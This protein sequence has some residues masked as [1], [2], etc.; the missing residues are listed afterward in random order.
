M[1]LLN[2]IQYNTTLSIHSQYCYESYWLLSLLLISWCCYVS[3]WVSFASFLLGAYSYSPNW[4]L[5]W[6]VEPP[7]ISVL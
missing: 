5:S 6:V 7:V 4:H 2:L 3:P 1:D